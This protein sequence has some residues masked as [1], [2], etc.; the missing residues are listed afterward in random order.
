MLFSGSL[1]QLKLSQLHIFCVLVT[2]PPLELFLERQLT[3]FF[4]NL[5]F[6]PYWPATFLTILTVI[7]R[8][9]LFGYMAWQHLVVRVYWGPS[10]E[11]YPFTWG[12]I[13]Q[14]FLV[15][16]NGCRSVCVVSLVT[17][18]NLCPL[19]PVVR[20]DLLRRWTEPSLTVFLIERGSFT[21]GRKPLGHFSAASQGLRV[22]AGNDLGQDMW[23]RV[24]CILCFGWGASAV[25]KS[26]EPLTTLQESPLGRS[27][28]SVS[29]SL[30]L[31][32]YTQYQRS[33]SGETLY[34]Q[35]HYPQCTVIKCIFNLKEFLLLMCPVIF[36]DLLLSRLK[37]LLLQLKLFLQQVLKSLLLSFN[38]SENKHG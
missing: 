29:S 38:W 17:A 28:H 26:R 11:T 13:L 15:R 18:Q 5:G 23:F 30:A 35:L 31:L 14:R 4:W 34:L 10:C 16:V 32:S 37:P 8:A 27:V 25:G 7:P 2:L 12:F 20:S 1:Q 21:L 36:S 22:S 33:E 6:F 24:L 9:P 19:C 3:H